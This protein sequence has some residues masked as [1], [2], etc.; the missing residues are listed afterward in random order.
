VVGPPSVEPGEPSASPSRDPEPQDQPGHRHRPGRSDAA[1]PRLAVT[2][3]PR[4]DQRPLT[5][6]RSSRASP[7]RARVERSTGPPTPARTVRCCGASTRGDCVPAARPASAQPHA[8]RAG[9]APGEPESNAP[10]GHRHRPGRCDAAGPRLAVTAS[11]RLDQRPLNHTP[12]EPGEPPASPSR[13]PEPN[14]QPRHRH[15]PERSDAA[16]RRPALPHHTLVEPGEPPASPSRDPEPDAPP[17]HRHRPGRSDAAGPRLAVTASPR[18]DQRGPTRRRSSRASPRRARVERSTGP[19]TPARTVRCCGAS[20]RGDSVPAARPA[21]A[22]PHAGRAGR[23][24]GEPESR[25]RAQRSTWPPTPARTM[26]CCGA[27]TRGDS[28]P[29]A[30]PASAQPHAGRAGRAPGEPESR[31]RAQRSTAPPT[32]ARTVRCCGAS[33]GVAAPHAGRAGRAPGEPESRPRA[34]RSTAP[35][36]PAR[37]VRCCGASTRGDC[38]PAAQP[39]WAR[40]SEPESRP[41]HHVSDPDLEP[42][43]TASQARPW[44]SLDLFGSRPRSFLA[45]SCLRR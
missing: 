23:A 35:P 39:A 29:A 26:R 19:P 11:P 37:T 34:Q 15:Q 42:P 4:L 44:G 24:P 13:D 1:G 12:V 7:R 21:S 28:V 30:R 31:P 27:S 45:R 16:G 38:V 2:P 20:T 17:G 10:P 9:R 14:A 18:L 36:T 6:R 5:T 8:G 41:P 43:V 33:A 40:A 22:Q 25:P 3:S 32:P